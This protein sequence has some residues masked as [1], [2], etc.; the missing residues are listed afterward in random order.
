MIISNSNRFIYIHTTKTAGSSISA[1]LLNYCNDTDSY[2][3]IFD[4][5][6]R[7]IVGNF[8]KLDHHSGI[9]TVRKFINN[10]TK[11]KSYLKIS[12]I[13]NPF[14]RMV[15]A[16][17]WFKPTY[18][19]NINFEEYVIGDYP[20]PAPLYNSLFIN[21]KLGVDFLIRYEYL[22]DDVSKLLIKLKKDNNVNIPKLKTNTRTDSKSYHHYYNDKLIDIIKKD[23]KMDL[24]IFNYK[25]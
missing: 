17:F 18:T 24:N 13:R 12:S 1:L 7:G 23:Y 3:S 20:H 8:D 11:F 5:N 14:D 10:D 19:K 2:T 25:F 22:N 6:K 16:Y 4:Y 21:N 9:N 15:S